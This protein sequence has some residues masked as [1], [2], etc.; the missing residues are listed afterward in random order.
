MKFLVNR[1]DWDSGAYI[2]SVIETFRPMFPFLSRVEMIDI[3]GMILRYVWSSGYQV[4]NGNTFRS[5]VI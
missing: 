3:L 1:Y 4:C 5:I 2:N